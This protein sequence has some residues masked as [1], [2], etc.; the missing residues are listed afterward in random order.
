MSTLG[1]WL[2]VVGVFAF[3]SIAASIVVAI[4]TF[5]N[6]IIAT[7]EVTYIRFYQEVVLIFLSI[8]FLLIPFLIGRSVSWFS[9]RGMRKKLEFNLK[10]IHCCSKSNVGFWT[11]GPVPAIRFWYDV[12][13]VL[14]QNRWRVK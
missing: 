13:H 4:Q 5:K 8:F 1:T 14:Y 6:R 11:L 9:E 2:T 10:V 3:L 7:D 12:E